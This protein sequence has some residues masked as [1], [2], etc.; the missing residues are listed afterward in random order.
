[1]NITTL[2]QL[3]DRC[4]KEEPNR[5]LDEA[6]RAAVD[7]QTVVKSGGGWDIYT[8]DHYTTSL[9][10]AM[11]L[12]NWLIITISD[13]AADGL[14]LVK[15]GNPGTSKETIGLGIA[16]HANL[17]I[18]FCAAALRARAEDLK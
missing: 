2:L 18:T 3:A 9:D 7:H 16:K 17:A 6:I 1:M 5:I 11:T 13:I 14:A 15:L 10:A 4:E 12:T 8:A